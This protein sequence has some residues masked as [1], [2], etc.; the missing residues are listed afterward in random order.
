MDEGYRTIII[1]TICQLNVSNINTSK[2]NVFGTGLSKKK[3]E[4]SFFRKRCKSVLDQY[5]MAY[6]LQKHSGT[7]VHVCC[8]GVNEVVINLYL[9]K[10]NED[11]E[12][13]IL[14]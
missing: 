4:Y 9:H 12:N 8:G 14:V 6:L 7:V 13:K 5:R 3:S 11:N 1:R 10:Q 2:L